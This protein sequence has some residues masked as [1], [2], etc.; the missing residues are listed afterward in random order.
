[1]ILIPLTQGKLAKVSDEDYVKLSIFRW[2]ASRTKRHGVERWYAR[3]KE[4]R[5]GKQ[6]T[7][8]MHREV[9]HCRQGF[10]VDHYPDR[11]GL[12]NQRENLRE[13][14]MEQNNLHTRF[15]QSYPA[16]SESSL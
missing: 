12:N 5:N 3:R 2:S 1:M 7:I 16:S 9:V 13:T 6:I 8:Y 15:R 10:V 14:T 11:D 4:M